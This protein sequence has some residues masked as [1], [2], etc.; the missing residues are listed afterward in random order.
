MLNES[1]LANSSLRTVTLS[2]VLGFD[3]MNV[4]N[5]EVYNLYKMK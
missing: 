2:T 5:L 4:E 1:C 3:L